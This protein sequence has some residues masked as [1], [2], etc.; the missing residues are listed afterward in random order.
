MLR[1]F[2]AKIPNEISNFRLASEPTW[3]SV[4]LEVIQSSADGSEIDREFL[5]DYADVQRDDREQYSSRSLALKALELISVGSPD[6]ADVESM[7]STLYAGDF[8]EGYGDYESGGK[9]YS[10]YEASGSFSLFNGNLV[11]FTVTLK[12]VLPDGSEI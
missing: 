12:P 7:K 4:S 3:Y 10:D 8:S 2:G 5:E 1:F 9:Y 6:Q 11:D